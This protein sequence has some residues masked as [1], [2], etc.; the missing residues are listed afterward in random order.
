LLQDVQ[1]LQSVVLEKA[2]ADGRYNSDQVFA[3]DGSRGEKLYS[4][5]VPVTTSYQLYRLKLTQKDG[6][7][8]YSPVI[9]LASESMAE[10]NRLWPNPAID[11]L[12]VKISTAA[13]EKRP[14]TIY[15]RNGLAVGRGTVHWNSGETT[16][17]IPLPPL[18]A[19]GLYQ[20]QVNMPGQ[21]ISFRFVK[22]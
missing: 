19:P 21:P 10:S 7:S 15:D 6:D 1:N 22:H 17:T 13:G 2:G 16:A 8:F 3:A 9:N 5:N 14:Y 20:L 18:L 12:N 4:T 11:Q